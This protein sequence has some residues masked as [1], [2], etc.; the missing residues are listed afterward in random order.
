MAGA[1][2]LK[3]L[4]DE[5][6]G[7]KGLLT[8]GGT[9]LC[10]GPDA[11]HLDAYLHDMAECKAHAAT[12]GPKSTSVFTEMEHRFNTADDVAALYDTLTLGSLVVRISS[13][14]ADAAGVAAVY[15]NRYQASRTHTPPPS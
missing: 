8:G 4:D 11:G 12:A 13:S 5:V 2:L 14:E 10:P 9:H 7:G 6:V 3:T 1:Y 15:L